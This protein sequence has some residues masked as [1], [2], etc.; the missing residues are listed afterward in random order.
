MIQ[1]LWNANSVYLST[2]ERR[3]LIV[4]YEG[5]LLQRSHTTEDMS[6]P[7][8]PPLPAPLS[9]PTS[10]RKRSF[11]EYREASSDP[12]LFS[13]D[14]PEPSVENYERA[15]RK[16]QH[17]RAWYEEPE[18]PYPQRPGVQGVARRKRKPFERN[19]DSGIY[20][21]SDDSS[22]LEPDEGSKT[23]GSLA[24]VN[25]EVG[26]RTSDH[27][28]DAET[29]AMAELV[30]PEKTA[31]RPWTDT[32]IEIWH[33]EDPMTFEGLVFPY[34]QP[35]PDDLKRFHDNQFFASLKVGRS[36]ETGWEILDLS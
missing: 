18:Y 23:V 21:G 28:N 11:D 12:A 3:D 36:V 15:Q 16:R 13:S 33:T 9:R 31:Q 6:F 27:G 8:L 35:Q 10:Y 26:S 20:M 29:E 32:D 7:G 14:G 19:F 25:N 4:L 34:W 2:Q 24:T 17:Q 30:S 1:P 22:N 5:A